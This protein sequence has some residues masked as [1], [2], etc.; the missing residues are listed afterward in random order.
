MVGYILFVLHISLR[1]LL[2]ANLLRSVTDEIWHAKFLDTLLLPTLSVL[3]V[4]LL[5][6]C[7]NIL[8]M[9]VPWTLDGAVVTKHLAFDM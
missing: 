4:F 6:I 9:I 7:S 8:F 2:I 1:L 5:G 3:L